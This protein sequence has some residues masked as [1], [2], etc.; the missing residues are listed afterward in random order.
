MYNRSIQDTTTLR[1]NEMLTQQEI[2]DFLNTLDF[3]DHYDCC[4]AIEMA[5]DGEE[6]NQVQKAFD[7]A[8]EIWETLN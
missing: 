8:Y 5:W 4:E 3:E 7:E 1:K 2:T 6:W